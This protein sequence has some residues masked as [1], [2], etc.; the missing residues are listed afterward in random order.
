MQT[1][2]LQLLFNEVIKQ[3]RGWSAKHADLLVE[4]IKRKDAVKAESSKQV[5]QIAHVVKDKL[6]KTVA[7]LQTRLQE[8]DNIVK[9]KVGA[10][11]L[12]RRAQDSVE[13]NFDKAM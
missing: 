10:L 3:I 5:K 2:T 8:V 9:L 4:L 13:L 7:K 12:T 6:A 11:D 1:K